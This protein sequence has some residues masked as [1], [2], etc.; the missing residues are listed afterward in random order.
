VRAGHV[1][2]QVRED[3]DGAEPVTSTPP[4]Q[5]LTVEAGCG[6]AHDAGTHA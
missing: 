6:R 5:I 3:M 2:A 4:R 1:L